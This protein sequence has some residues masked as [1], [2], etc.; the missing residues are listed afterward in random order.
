VIE[1]DEAPHS[2]LPV[3]ED[4]KMYLTETHRV[5]ECLSN[6]PPTMEMTETIT[7]D[8]IKGVL[9]TD[10][11]KAADERMK[12]KFREMADGFFNKGMKRVM[13]YMNPMFCVKSGENEVVLVRKYAMVGFDD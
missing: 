5:S 2:S 13:V 12:D 9:R 4:M 6:I 8:P 7:G 11:A 3:Y 10:E 1:F